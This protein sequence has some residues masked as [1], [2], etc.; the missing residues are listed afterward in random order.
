MSLQYAHVI[1]HDDMG[2]ISQKD[3][4]FRTATSM[5]CITKLA[6]RQQKDTLKQNDTGFRQ[7]RTDGKFH[8]NR[9]F[10]AAC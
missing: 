10:Y 3:H 1:F 6:F 9:N 4:I 7:G 8:V 2:I 5:S